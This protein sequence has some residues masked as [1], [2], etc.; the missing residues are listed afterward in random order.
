MVGSDSPA[1]SKLS[2]RLFL[3]P[4]RRSFVVRGLF[5]LTAGIGLRRGGWQW[6]K[7]VRSFVLLSI[8]AL[9]L[10]VVFS[11]NRWV[12]FNLFHPRY[13]SISLLLLVSSLSLIAVSAQR[14]CTGRMTALLVA[15]ATAAMVLGLLAVEFPNPPEGRQRLLRAAEKSWGFRL[16][17]LEARNPRFITGNYWFAWT[18]GF[19][20]NA[21][22]GHQGRGD[23][24]VVLSGR[25]HAIL[26]LV[27]KAVRT[28][29]KPLLASGKAGDPEFSK[30]LGQ[31][32]LQSVRAIGCEE[33]VR[34]EELQFLLPMPERQPDFSPPPRPVSSPFLL[35]RLIPEK[36]FPSTTCAAAISPPTPAGS[37]PAH[38]SNSTAP[39]PSP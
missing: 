20:V 24:V 26:D 21:E 1:S 8:C 36:G 28:T 30:Y 10:P 12:A 16:E 11:L 9:I 7:S 18:A 27:K 14:L 2:Q 29:N 39:A 32:F 23:R 15:S 5:F 3:F 34:T 6:V 35:G 22:R 25:S 13:S 33:G 4:P 17:N 38:Q 19:L 37:L 31:V